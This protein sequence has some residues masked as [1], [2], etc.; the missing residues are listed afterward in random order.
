MIRNFLEWCFGVKKHPRFKLVPHTTLMLSGPRVVY[1]LYEWRQSS[2]YSGNS[3][4]KIESYI[5][6]EE[7]EAVIKE[8]SQGPIFYD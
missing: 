5:R 6:R 7:A 2:K 1:T 4:V 8:A 3:W